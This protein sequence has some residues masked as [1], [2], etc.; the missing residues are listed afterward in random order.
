MMLFNLNAPI[1]VRTRPTPHRLLVSL[2][3]TPRTSPGVTSRPGERLSIKDH[4]TRARY[5]GPLGT[6]ASFGVTACLEY[7]C[8]RDLSEACLTHETETQF[9]DCQAGSDIGTI[10][11]GAKDNGI[12][13]E[14]FWRY[15]FRQ[16]CWTNPGPPDVS[17]RPRF[18]FNDVWLLFA[19]PRTSILQVMCG[20][21]AA[22]G[23]DKVGM[24]KQVLNQF[25]IPV[26]VGVPVFTIGENHLDAGWE[27]GP[28][29]HLP[30]PAALTTFAEMDARSVAAGEGWHTLPICGYDDSL[31][32]FEFKNS[33]GEFW[34]KTT[35]GFGTIA[36]EYIDRYADNAFA[37]TA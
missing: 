34:G 32:R 4:M 30:T 22:A 18:A 20:A 19:V 6:C 13:E 14:E 27:D 33:W 25:R 11:V 28:D 36:Y 5:Q 35:L 23:V 37:A 1:R 10:M 12:V 16:I 2:P 8:Q 9:G 26:A 29:I 15:D 31:G 3:R 17:M 7:F 21:T 24:I